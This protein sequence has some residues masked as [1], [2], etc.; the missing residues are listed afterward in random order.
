MDTRLRLLFGL[1]LGLL[2]L[3][4]AVRALADHEA[5]HGPSLQALVDATPAGGTLTPPPG[6]YAGP[7]V[8][9]KPMTLD[10]AGAVTIDN[11]GHGTVVLVQGN[12]ITVQGL[13]LRNSGTL[14]DRV[15]AGVQVR[16]RY[17]VI[18]DTV[19]ENCLFGID[20]QQSD[21]NVLRRNRITSQAIDLGLRGDAIR[22]WYSMDN[23]LQGNV[24]EDSRDVVVWYS[25]DNRIT[26]N[27]MR[28]GRYGIHFMYSHFNLVEDNEFESNT[29]GIFLMYSNDVVV[30]R[31]RIEYSQGPSGIGI[32][33]KETSGTVLT[34]NDI[35]GNATGIYLDV[36]PYDPESDNRFE[37]NRIA[38]NGI[39]VL[40][41][42]D[43]QGNHFRGNDF[44]G[45]FTQVSVSGGGSA[46]RNQ[47]AGNHWDV[48]EG[49][50]TDRDGT[51]DTPF[52]AHAYADRLWMDV[53]DARF[54]R[55]SPTLELLDFMERLA[56][57]SAPRLLLRDERPAMAR[58]MP[59][60]K[61]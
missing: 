13:T 27:R 44:I 5:S 14:H 6:V 12:G 32:G 9:A 46:K 39:A 26:G 35:L 59:Q 51:G 48:Y 49:F 21:S 56:P 36:S 42:S 22:L 20:L 61:G 3:G 58:T 11:G 10:G 24:I 45:N 54:F 33:F 40:F 25:K 31:N 23:S 1:G 52:E 47:W 7:V 55:G 18:K 50:D 53:P 29:V 15:D 16:G 34:G 41:H 30:R 60:G 4:T 57:F 2:L 43:W 17:N 28:R 37:G 8:I 38:F 19:I